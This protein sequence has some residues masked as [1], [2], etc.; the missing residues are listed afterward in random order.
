MTKWELDIEDGEPTSPASHQLSQHASLPWESQAS[1]AP[2][3]V[4]VQQGV[5]ACMSVNLH[6]P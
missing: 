2:F 4:V 5:E 6:R 1:A 3:K